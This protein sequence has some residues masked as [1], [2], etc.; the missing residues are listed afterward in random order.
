[1]SDPE[2]NSFSSVGFDFRVSFLS[3]PIRP[4]FFFFS[5]ATHS[6]WVD[7]EIVLLSYDARV[8]GYVGGSKVP[9]WIRLNDPLL[10]S[11]WIPCK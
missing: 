7:L 4:D 9:R 1:M 11:K 10:A 3:L 6:L 2:P 5:P 8:G